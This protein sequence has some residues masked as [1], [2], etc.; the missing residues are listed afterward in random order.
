MIKNEQTVERLELRVSRFDRD[1]EDDGTVRRRPALRV[2]DPGWA[3]RAW[4]KIERRRRGGWLLAEGGWY[5]AVSGLVSSAEWQWEE[6]LGPS[7]SA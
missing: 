2:T 4:E 7:G 3:L 1:H 6:S 5:L